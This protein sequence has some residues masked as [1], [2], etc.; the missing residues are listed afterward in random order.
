VPL[1]VRRW[2]TTR[3]IR[4]VIECDWWDTHAEKGMRFHCVPAQHFSGRAPWSDRN[5]SLWCGWV[6]DAPEGRVYF[7]G[8]TGYGPLFREIGARLGPMRLSLIP[9]GAYSPRWFMRGVHVDPA[10]AVQI[11]RDV[12]SQRS[13]GMHWGTFRLT[14]EPPAEPPI[15]LAHA[16]AAAGLAAGEF[17][18]LR[19][20]ETIHA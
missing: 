4:N 17:S 19:F 2:F 6:I 8:D 12:R 3:G 7:A 14:S 13:I 9:I 5:K 16:A 1:N 11:H 20:G 10:E 15:Y 18:V